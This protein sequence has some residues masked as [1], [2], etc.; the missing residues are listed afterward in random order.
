M[1]LKTD[2]SFNFLVDFTRVIISSFLSAVLLL[3][4]DHPS[5]VKIYE[6]FLI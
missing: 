4:N 5:T 1:V 6:Q 3:N 2:S